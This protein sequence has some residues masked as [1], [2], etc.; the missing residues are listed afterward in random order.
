MLQRFTDIC[1]IFVVITKLWISNKAWQQLINDFYCLSVLWAGPMPLLW[2][3]HK[4]CPHT[5]HLLWSSYSYH[6]H[7]RVL[8]LSENGPCP[9]FVTAH[10]DV[11][12]RSWAH[13]LIWT[14]LH[15]L[16][17]QGRHQ[18]Q[19]SGAVNSQ[20]EGSLGSDWPIRGSYI[21]RWPSGKKQT[22]ERSLVFKDE[23]NCSLKQMRLWYLVW[24]I[25]RVYGW[26]IASSEHYE[27]YCLLFRRGWHIFPKI[28][29]P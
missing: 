15:P 22:R 13:E 19:W 8:H 10:V 21:I 14:K 26:N 24:Y 5:A 3:P 27:L 9:V 25:Q 23:L 2:T 1:K 16:S 18:T 7:G 29:V 17:R 6:S 12:D 11:P 20:S 4:S 28:S